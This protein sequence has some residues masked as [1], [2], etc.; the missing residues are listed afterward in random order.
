M[1]PH[2]VLDEIERRFALGRRLSFDPHPQEGELGR[3]WR[4]T[5]T[6][7]TWAVKELLHPQSEA[8]V[9]PGVR[10]Q[11]TAVSAG[12][13]APTVVRTTDGSVLA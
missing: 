3:V 4:L 6:E 12:L 9:L 11:E 10:L 7:G 13:P 2:H 1:M 5:T 8:E